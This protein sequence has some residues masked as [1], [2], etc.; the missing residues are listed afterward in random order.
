M[1]KTYAF[2]FME[3][4]RQAEFKAFSGLKVYKY[5]LSLKNVIVRSDIYCVSMMSLKFVQSAN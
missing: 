1:E 5:S 4:V 3:K 2:C